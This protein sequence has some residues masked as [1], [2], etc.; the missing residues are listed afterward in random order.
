MLKEDIDYEVYK[1]PFNRNTWI[2]ALLL[3]LFTTVFIIIS[4]KTQ[5]N[6]KFSLVFMIKVLTA[7]LKANL[8]ND[9]FSLLRT[10]LESFKVISFSA[11]LFGNILWLT[12][13]G[14]LLSALVTPK[15]T[16]PFNDLESFSKS[17]Y[18]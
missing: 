12:Y 18:R 3:S 17:S 7:S 14:A 6:T 13:N 2:A 8:G 16:K 9:T 1:N 10:E 4:W 15:V 5:K 11:L